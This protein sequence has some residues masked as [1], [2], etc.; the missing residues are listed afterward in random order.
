MN[1]LQ[2][3]GISAYYRYCHRSGYR[4]RRPTDA[5]IIYV[6]LIFSDTVDDKQWT[7][8]RQ[9][10]KKTVLE[11][12]N[13]YRVIYVTYKLLQKYYV[14]S[15]SIQCTRKQDAPRSLSRDNYTNN[16]H[17]N[18]RKVKHN[19]YITNRIT[20]LWLTQCL[21]VIVCK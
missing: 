5:I 12:L 13:K 19:N 1:G 7:T 2:S 18:E 20:I 15:M 14:Y 8:H 9:I 6:R 10:E 17:G 16:T 21:C 11:T 4:R 3:R